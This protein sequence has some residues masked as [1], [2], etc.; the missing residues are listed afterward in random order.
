MTKL[1]KRTI[2][3]VV[4]EQ[5]TRFVNSIMAMLEREFS[6]DIDQHREALFES[7]QKQ[8]ENALGYGLST[9]YELLIYVLTAVFVDSEFD[10]RIPA[11]RKR[12]RDPSLNGNQKANWLRYFTISLY[13]ELEIN[14]VI[15]ADRIKTLNRVMEG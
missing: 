8:V 13:E 12:L 14:G 2:N 6:V 11:A 7:V 4:Q 10:Q 1:S 3:T 9:D 5:I 15:S